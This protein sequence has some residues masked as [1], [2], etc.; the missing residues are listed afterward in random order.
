MGINF[1]NQKNNKKRIIISDINITPFVDILLVLLIIFMVAA[2]MMTSNIKIDLP[3][4]AAAPSNE[5]AQPIAISIKD[6]GT[7]FIQDDSVK[8]NL[9]ST[10]LLELSNNNL[11]SK[12]QVR[13]DKKID[14]G[15]VM[16]IIRTV[17][18]S[19]FTQ[20]VLVTELNQ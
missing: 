17:N 13:A 6:D 15:R 16:D 3:K 18:L 4:G 8:L 14:Y 10:R 1:T 11:N 12:I 5:K 20:V 7:I 19:G 2:P 9:L